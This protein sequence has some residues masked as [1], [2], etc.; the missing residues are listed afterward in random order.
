MED[1]LFLSRPFNRATLQLVD[2][3]LLAQAGLI[4]ERTR[5][6]APPGSSIVQAP[7]QTNWQ[8][9]DER[10]SPLGRL[11]LRVADYV[12]GSY[13]TTTEEAERAMK[14]ILRLLY[15]DPLSEGY[16]LPEAFH[17]TKLGKLFDQ[18]RGA[19]WDQRG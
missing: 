14:Q 5:S 1:P 10:H 6:I 2:D 11:L 13:S 15:G 17:K 7:W 16:A 12:N 19:S 8:G 9:E 18:A 3:L 4:W